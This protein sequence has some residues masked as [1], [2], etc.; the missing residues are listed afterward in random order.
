[1]SDRHERERD[2]GPGGD[3]AGEPRELEVAVETE[4]AG[5]A[6]EPPAPA[7][8]EIAALRRERDELKDQLLRKRADLENYR[9][10]VERDRRSVFSDASADVIRS[11]LP[12][13]DN[14][15]RALSADAPERPLREGVELVQRELLA[16]LEARGVSVEDPLGQA[17]DPERHEALAHEV[18]PGAT[19]GTVV[20]VFRK[21]YRL[22]DKLLRPALV[23]V[24]K[25]PSADGGGVA[26]PGE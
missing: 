12:T 22:H 5:A 24:A 20:E 14:L 2:A 25:E 18:V 15:E 4:E 10:R 1:V 3:D 6:P 8:G 11:V 17:F 23:K 7:A 19:P 21:A 16:A 13:L 9:R 26:V